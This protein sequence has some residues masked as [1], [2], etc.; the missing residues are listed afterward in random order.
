MKLLR[1]LRN[2]INTCEVR[3]GFDVHCNRI[4]V[5]S[6]CFDATQLNSHQ[7]YFAPSKGVENQTYGLVE[8]CLRIEPVTDQCFV[9]SRVFFNIATWKCY[10]RLVIRRCIAENEDVLLRL[11]LLF[12]VSY[13]LKLKPRSKEIDSCICFPIASGFINKYSFCEVPSSRRRSK[14]ALNVY[15]LG[16]KYGRQMVG[17]QMKWSKFIISV[18]LSG[19][20]RHSIHLFGNASGQL[21]SVIH[22][23]VKI[24]KLHPR[25]YRGN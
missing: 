19:G 18:L 22:C 7:R 17:K 5:P 14:C 23:L 9:Q 10:L 15:I 12:F 20:S 25:I 24:S 13:K 16:Y 2:L 4:L 21:S 1:S 8:W 6:S 11:K 3:N